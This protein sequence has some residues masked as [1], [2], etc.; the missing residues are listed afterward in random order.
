MTLLSLLIHVG[1]GKAKHHNKEAPDM[2]K[3]LSLSVQGRYFLVGECLS[4]K[5]PSETEI[6]SSAGLLSPSLGLSAFH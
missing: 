5:H 3:D 2:C 4:F 6:I 1:E